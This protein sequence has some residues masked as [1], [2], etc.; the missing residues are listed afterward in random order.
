MGR[1]GSPTLGYHAED[2]ENDIPELNKCPSCGAFFE[3][4]V[5]PICK[6][7]CPEEMKAGNRVVR[8]KKKKKAKSSGYQVPPVWYLRTWFILLVL[9]F[10]QLFGLIL[11]WM[12]DW[13]KWVKV[14]VT[15]LA[16]GGGYIV[17]IVLYP[18]LG[19][20]QQQ[21][22][23]E[24]VNYDIPESE[25][26]E[27]CDTLD[28]EDMMREPNAYV[29]RYMTLT[30]TVQSVKYINGYNGTFIG[31]VL[32]TVDGDGHSYVIYDCRKGGKGIL[33]G[34]TVQVFGELGCVS[35]EAAFDAYEKYPIV[36][37]AYVDLVE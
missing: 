9:C 32:L 29:G 11:V 4:D 7:V 28:Y 2:D 35:T 10:S 12:S 15:I 37:G 3:D 16:L 20:L 22:P 18:L 23:I 36:Y 34:D 26:R 17:G 13:K 21:K 25:Y 19:F 5:C 14:T 8:K 1:F 24:Y 31:D 6:T 30:L 33:A 27:Q